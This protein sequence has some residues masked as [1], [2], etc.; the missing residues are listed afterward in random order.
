MSAYFCLKLDWHILYTTFLRWKWWTVI[1]FCLKFVYGFVSLDSKYG[2][3]PKWPNGD[4]FLESIRS[5]T[6]RVRSKTWFFVNYSVDH[7]I[8]LL[9]LID[10][11]IR[12]LNLVQ[13]LP[14]NNSRVILIAT[15]QLQ[16][17]ITAASCSKGER[18]WCILVWIAL[19]QVTWHSVLNVE[20]DEH[21]S[22]EWNKNASQ[23]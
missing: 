3:L 7:H 4:K 13:C 15:K 1:F 22:L 20:F 19:T 23:K 12:P 16:P 6:L 17:K 14:L 18:D 21:F 11:N 5:P 9:I 2:L 10:L 8:I